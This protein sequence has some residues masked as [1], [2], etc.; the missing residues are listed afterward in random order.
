MKDSIMP[1]GTPV[2]Q[3]TFTRKHRLPHPSAARECSPSY[4][5]CLMDEGFFPS[6]RREEGANQDSQPTSNTGIGKKTR[7]PLR[8]VAESSFLPTKSENF[9]GKP[10][11]STF[12]P[13][14]PC[15]LHCSASRMLE[16]NRGR[17]MPS[18]S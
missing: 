2:V 7:P 6:P 9:I 1:A 16:I 17:Q 13:R 14:H 18:Y 15:L 12:E 5:W 8:R 3:Q 4:R 10:G 11:H